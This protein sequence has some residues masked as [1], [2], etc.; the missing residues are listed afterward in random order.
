MTLD[1]EDIEAI[2]EAVALKISGRT[3]IID[4]V[5]HMVMMIKSGRR[6]EV[7]AAQRKKLFAER[8]VQK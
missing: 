2:A 7:N 1:A 8:R 6:D 3:A 4:E 5:E